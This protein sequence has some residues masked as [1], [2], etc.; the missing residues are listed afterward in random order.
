MIQFVTEKE[1]TRPKMAVRMMAAL[2]S[3]AAVV[4]NQ[5][6]LA[7]LIFIKPELNPTFHP[8]GEYALGRLGW[9]QVLAFLISA[10]SYGAMFV[11]IRGQIRDGLGTVGL[12]IVWLVTLGWHV[13]KLR[14][15]ETPTITE[16]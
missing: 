4:T 14:G 12:A 16:V 9:I 15:Q 6:V 3:I 1:V 7:A 8:I 2:L 10:V 5:A 13:I 11:A